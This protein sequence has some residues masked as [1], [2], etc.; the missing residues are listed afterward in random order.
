MNGDIPPNSLEKGNNGEGNERVIIVT[1]TNEEKAE[2][3]KE[4]VEPEMNYQTDSK[5]SKPLETIV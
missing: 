1:E 4:N 3:K 2:G 5:Q